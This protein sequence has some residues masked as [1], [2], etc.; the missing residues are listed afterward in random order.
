M[1][2][3]TFLHTL[4][5]CQN[6]FTELTEAGI[7]VTVPRDSKR[8][9]RVVV[10]PTRKLNN[11]VVRLLTLL[12]YVITP[13]ELVTQVRQFKLTSRKRVALNVLLETLDFDRTSIILTR[14]FGPK[15]FLHPDVAYDLLMGAGRFS[16]YALI[17]AKRVAIKA[18]IDPAGN[19]LI[20]SHLQQRVVRQAQVKIEPNLRGI[21]CVDWYNKLH[22]SLW[23]QTPTCWKQVKQ[24]RQHPQVSAWL[25]QVRLFAALNPPPE[26]ATL[27]KN[28]RLVAQVEHFNKT[29][30]S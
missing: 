12:T 16:L 19:I 10:D 24:P 5:E 1:D 2:L 30:N 25:F 28:E 18:A 20:S 17:I 29:T 15:K 21:V 14:Y 9:S 7:N 13:E 27:F 22:W 8:M 3:H 6:L 23:Q 4:D 11:G 26:T